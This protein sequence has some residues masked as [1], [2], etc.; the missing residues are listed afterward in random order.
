MEEQQPDSLEEIQA[1]INSSKPDFASEINKFIKHIES[2]ADIVPIVMSLISLKL[3]QESRHVEQYIKDS[4]IIEKK[5][6]ESTDGDEPKQSKLLVPSD[7]FK[8]FIELT[9]K[10]DKTGLAYQ[11]LPI[12]FVVSF[13]SQYDAYLGGLIRTMFFAKP[14]LLNGSEKNILFSE[15]M[16]FASIEDA[17]EFLIEKEVE[18]VLR[19]SHLKQ[20]KWLENKLGITLRKDLPSF[21][22]FIEIT[23]R[24]NLFVHCNGVV[25][26]QYIDVCRENEV[27]NIDEI[28]VGEQLSAKPE[29]FNKCYQILFEI[30]VK[31]GQVTWRKLIPDEIEKADAHLNNVCYQLLIKGH[32][33][34]A[35]K[36]LTFAT[37]TI[38]KHADQEMVC[39]FTINKALA[40]YL[41]NKK[42]ECKKVLEKHD[43]S[44]TNDKYKLAIAVLKEESEDAIK[45][46]K[47]I[48]STSKDVTKDAYREWPLFREFRKTDTFKTAYVEIFEEEFI[49]VEPKP[50][51]LEDIVSEMQQ[52]KK[53]ALE[54]RE[55]EN[56]APNGD[57]E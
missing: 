27:K 51:N 24:R 38:K 33:R 18:S 44:A 43:W 2:Q 4:G 37:D 42:E 10:V 40:H 21:S 41:S 30:G 16:K 19:E 49:Y 35:L 48:G 23:E 36:L 54:V 3:V 6:D 46:M 39:I 47:S 12:N 50:K 1:E 57:S 20:F 31:L 25:S 52:L 22:D 13:V 17:K 14:E 45:L 7:K 9:E 15:L 26:R 11:L 5:K 53:E 55:K 28:K 32:N 8:G 29:Y 56:T 34:L